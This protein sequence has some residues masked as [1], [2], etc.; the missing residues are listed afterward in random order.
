MAGLVLAPSLKCGPA[1]AVPA[2]RV[3]V[4]ESG[5]PLTHETEEAPTCVPQD[6]VAGIIL[7]LLAGVFSGGQFAVIAI[8]K[9]FTAP[10]GM[11]CSDD[12]HCGNM[13][14]TSART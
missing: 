3:E 5:Q 14:D 4:N 11:S 6:L 7:A 10:D 1:E 2:S 8:G 12:V 13:F 9:K